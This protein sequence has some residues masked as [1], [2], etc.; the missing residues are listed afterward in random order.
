[1]SHPS[2]TRSR[3]SPDPRPESSAPLRGGTAEVVKLALPVVL[4]HLSITAMQI[5]DSIMVG[6]L[7]SPQLASV[8]FGG[9]WLWTLTC[10]FVGTTT[11]VQTFV[12]QHYGAGNNRACGSW[13]WQAI[14]VLGPMT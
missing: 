13:A 8:G 3:Q 6:Q 4:T 14:Y 11:C 9:V 12:S 5:V 1:M 7:G 2:E 10:F